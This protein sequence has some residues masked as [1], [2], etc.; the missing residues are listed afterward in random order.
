MQTTHPTGRSPLNWLVVN[1][2]GKLLAVLDSESEARWFTRNRG[3]AVGA[4]VVQSTIDYAQAPAL[5][6]A[7]RAI[8]EPDTLL[9]A[10]GEAF[11]LHAARRMQEQARSAITSATV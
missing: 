7:L 10:N 2:D 8:S 9:D 6:E 1:P 3:H 11:G 5:A 4:S